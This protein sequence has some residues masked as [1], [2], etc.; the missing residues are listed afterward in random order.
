VSDIQA[1]KIQPIA[2]VQVSIDIEGAPAVKVRFL[3]IHIVPRHLV[4]YY[5]YEVVQSEDG[6]IE[7]TWRCTCV[8][9]TGDKVLKPGPNGEQRLSSKVGHTTDWY[10][11]DLE[12]LPEFVQKWVE[13][14]RPSG[15]LDLTQL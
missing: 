10:G 5:R 8:A 4:I 15:R 14:A 12:E 2:T 3:S 9:A 1:T 6:W 11:R 7:Y 13:D